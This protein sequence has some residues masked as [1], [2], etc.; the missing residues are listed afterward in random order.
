MVALE[1]EVVQASAHKLEE[2]GAYGLTL[3]VLVMRQSSE[4]LTMSDSEELKSNTEVIKSKANYIHKNT[5]RKRI[6]FSRLWR[7][8]K[9]KYG[10]L[11]LCGALLLM[12]MWLLM[13]S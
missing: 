1:I 13:K 9:R 11:L 12:F 6:R 7:R 4:I 3:S 10:F 8:I 5:D 2:N